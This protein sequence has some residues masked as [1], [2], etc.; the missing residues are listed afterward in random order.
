M[1]KVTHV[2]SVQVIPE[3]KSIKQLE[4]AAQI[5]QSLRA[6][7]ALGQVPISFSPRIR[8][9]LSQMETDILII[10]RTILGTK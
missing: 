6:G 5:M 4:V 2:V 1:K 10:R 3:N 7:P 8:Q 9:L